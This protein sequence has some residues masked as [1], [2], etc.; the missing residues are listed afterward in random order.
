MAFFGE[1]AA[2]E[3]DIHA[4]MNMAATLSCPT[5]FVCRNN[6]Y[7]IS[8]GTADQVMCACVCVCVCVCVWCMRSVCM[9]GGVTLL[10]PGTIWFVT[11]MCVM[12]VCVWCVRVSNVRVCCMCCEGGRAVVVIQMSTR[13]YNGGVTMQCF[14]VLEYVKPV[15][16]NRVI[17][18]S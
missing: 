9:G 16:V 6:G 11:S 2:S 17:R 18:K 4:A 12:C 13:F 8:T 15:K 7:A 10:E 1:G 3:G 5:L 14:S